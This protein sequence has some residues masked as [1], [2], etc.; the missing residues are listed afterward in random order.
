MKLRLALAFVALTVVAGAVSAWVAINTRY[1]AF[2]REVFVDV[3]R[4]TGTASMAAMLEKA[5][6]IRHRWLLLA[7]RVMRPRTVLQAGEY[8]FHEPATPGEVFDR[9]ARGDIFYHTL[10]VLEGHNIFDIA[11]SVAE[12]GFIDGGEFLKAAQDA[13]MIRDLAP[14]APTL[15][16]YLFPSTYQVIRQTTATQLCRMMTDQFRKIWKSLETTAPVHRTVTLAS[17]VEREAAVPEERPL[18]A[19]VFENRLREAMPLQCDPTTIYAALLE[20]RY[21]GTIYQSD[22]SSNH[23][24]NTY[25]HP[26]L[27][28]G[29]IANSGQKSLEA[30]LHP[31][32]TEYLYFVA[33]PDGSGA[34]QFSKALATHQQAVAEYRRA[35]RKAN[36]AQTPSRAH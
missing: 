31:A 3:P 13:S 18:I 7:A 32:E 6:V 8:R 34:H 9:L 15:E 1:S 28:P 23:P 11:R 16:G 24:Y 26:G 19:S 30:A 36:S 17:L 2:D 12:L 33:K 35:L 5:G 29:P 22:L 21:R 27:P 4:G 20:G 25:R 14:E 10:T